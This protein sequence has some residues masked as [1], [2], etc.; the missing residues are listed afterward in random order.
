MTNDEAVQ[1]LERVLELTNDS[2][3]GEIRA[4]IAGIR[5]GL[6]K[7]T[8][9]ALLRKVSKAQP[10]PVKAPAVTKKKKAKKKL[11]SFFRSHA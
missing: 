9:A 5:A 1:C 4:V 10:K 6:D 3:K 7:P 2:G 11:L 8:F